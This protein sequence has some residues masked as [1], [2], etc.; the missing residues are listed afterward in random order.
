MSKIALITGGTDGIGKA[1]AIEL[2]KLGYSVQILG[3]N[4]KRGEEVVKS[5][6]DINPPGKHEL[7]ILDLSMMN[8]VKDFLENYRNAYQALDVLILSAGIYPTTPQISADGIDKSFS[9]GY[10][11]RYLFAARLDKM[12]GNSSIG[13]VVH[14]N[15]GVFGKIYYDQ[16]KEPNY[17]R[18]KGVWQN[19][20]AGALLVYNWKEISGS[21]VAHMHWLP[22]LVKTNILNTQGFLVK[23]VLAKLIGMEPGVAGKMLADNI[24]EV[25]QQDTTGKFYVQG[26]LKKTPKKIQNGKSRLEELIKFSTKFTSCPPTKNAESAT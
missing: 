11:S 4:K 1:T 23:T 15:G 19:S 2:A 13:K 17:S 8:D 10:I 21:N 12:L 24:E 18:I 14:V 5:L 3:R 6:R 7:F 25:S 26:K 22:G 20:V 16:L 9:I